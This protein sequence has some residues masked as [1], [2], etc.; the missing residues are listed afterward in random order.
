MDEGIEQRES[1][2]FFPRKPNNVN[3]FFSFFTIIFLVFA[4]EFVWGLICTFGN[5][6]RPSTRNFLKLRVPTISVGLEREFQIMSSTTSI[7]RSQFLRDEAYRL[8]S[9]V[10]GLAFEFIMRARK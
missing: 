8:F 10:L 5:K 3:N 7:G 2:C 4:F 6:K 9:S 1:L